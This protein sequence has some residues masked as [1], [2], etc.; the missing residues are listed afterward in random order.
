MA[1]IYQSP[2]SLISVLRTEL[3]RPKPAPTRLKAG[4]YA[5]VS[6]DPPLTD[7]NVRSEPGINQD[8]IGSI[9]SGRAVELLEGP[10]CNN[11]LQWWKV[12][13]PETGLVGWSPE[14]AHESYWLVACESKANCGVP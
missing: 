5:A 1:R 10:V 14:G 2:V 12:R 7:N 6:I 3:F 11:S 13:V 4:G 9:A 8:L